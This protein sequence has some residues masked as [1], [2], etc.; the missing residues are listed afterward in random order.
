MHP[1]LFVRRIMALHLCCN[2]L[3]GE[4]LPLLYV[5]NFD[6]ANIAPSLWTTRIL[7]IEHF[8]EMVRPNPQSRKVCVW[9]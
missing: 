8:E 7:S 9:F 4:A 2:S 5:L 6:L 1:A 3:A